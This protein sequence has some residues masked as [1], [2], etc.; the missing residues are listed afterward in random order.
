MTQQHIHVFLTQK[1]KQLPT[2]SVADK[3][4]PS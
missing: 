3:D 4:N 2:T 1:Y